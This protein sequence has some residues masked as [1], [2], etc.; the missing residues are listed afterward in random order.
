MRPVAFASLL[1]F[2]LLTAQNQ[3]A[4][5]TTGVETAIEVPFDP[6]IVPPTGLTVEAWVTYDDTTIPTTSWYWPTIARQNI[7]PQHASWFLRVGASNTAAR[8]LEFLVEDENAVL[9]TLS[10]PFAASALAS[11]TH[12]AATF[13]GQVM[14]LFVNG[15]QVT[16]RTLARRFEIVDNGGILRI[17][18]GDASR[19]GQE[20]WNGLIDE[21][22]VWPMPR[23]Q[24][25]IA[26]TMQQALT[27]M[28]GGVLTFNLDG[29][30][31]DTSHGLF[32]VP[33]GAVGYQP[34]PALPIVS[35]VTLAAGPGTTTCQRSIDLAL[36]SAPRIGNGAFA[37]WC[38]KVTATAPLGLAVLAAR[39]APATQPPVLGVALAFDLGSIAGQFV[40]VPGGTGLG[41]ARLALP[42]PNLPGLSGVG[43]VAQFGFVDGGCGPQGFTAS[44]GL[45]FA[46]K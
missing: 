5:F 22:R 29:H 1:V 8:N 10:W 19:P 20:A 14:R 3:A 27:S 9:Y 36:G 28:P 18:N 23:T 33:F 25:E 41:V 16:S 7:V 40:L 11:W 21:L 24:A 43:F 6:A 12:L 26:A 37:L 46:I 30:A 39:P 45:V 15:A 38:T 17:G 42:V 35:P 32:G 34:A 13:D 4:Q 44:D 31:V 2:Q